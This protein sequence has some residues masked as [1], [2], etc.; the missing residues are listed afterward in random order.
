MEKPIN[1]KKST[2]L[3]SYELDN[4]VRTLMD[5]QKI[6]DDPE[7]CKAVHSHAKKQKK[8]LHKV[9]KMISHKKE[10][11]ME[12]S[13]YHDMES[14]DDESKEIKS[15]AQIRARSKKLKNKLTKVE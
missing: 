4:H 5:A 7:L 1:P 10:E 2:K 14:E 12:S 13:E 9:S 8:S 6:C 15:I 11:D 3:E